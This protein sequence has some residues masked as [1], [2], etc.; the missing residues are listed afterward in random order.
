[1]G[2]LV[3]ASVLIA[4]IVAS[5]ATTSLAS[6]YYVAKWGD[7]GDGGSFDF[8]W[9]TIGKA[10]SVLV[11]GDTV[12]I[13]E[14]IYKESVNPS[15]SGTAG[16]PIV[17]E[18][19]QN[20]EIIVEGYE[21]IT[22]WVQDSVNRYMANVDFIPG[23]R[24]TTARD[25]RGNYG[26]LVLQDG[27]K[28]RYAMSPSQVD[29]DSAGEYYMD[30]SGSPPFTMYVYV[31]DLGS[32]YDPNNYVMQVGRYRKLFDLDGG[33]D[34]IHVIG[35]TLRGANDNA[36][37]SIGSN[38]CVFRRMTT[39][40]NFIT[41]I[42]LT[43][44]SR[45]GVIEQ[46]EF[47]D[48][49]HGGIELARAHSTTIRRNKFT[50][51]DL[52]NGFGG[53]GAHMWLG[54]LT[55]Y[56]DSCLI[57]NNIGFRTGS[58][59]TDIAFVAIR[60]EYNTVRHNSFLD[61]G[62]GGIA[63]IYGGNNTVINNAVNCTRGVACINVFPDAVAAGGHFI[64]YNDFYAEDP[65]GKYRWDGV[66]YDSLADW[67]AASGQSNNID[68]IPLWVDPA[69]EDLY[70]Q[71]GSDC[72]DAGTD[73]NASSEDY[74]GTPRPQGSGYDIGA[75]EYVETGVA[76]SREQVLSRSSLSL[77]FYPNPCA[78]EV[79]INY[80]I[81]AESL[82]VLQIYDITGRLVKSFAPG[83]QSPGTH[84]VN[85]RGDDDFGT[86]CPSGIYFCQLKT[87]RSTITEKLVLV[88]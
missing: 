38:Y 50:R 66:A 36:V 20:E 29:V 1:M 37:H 49:G 4:I 57:E 17:Y 81:Y 22:G 7:N 63:L 76:E 35:L 82:V 85:W 12:F 68:S 86:N 87:G 16:D 5:L 39:Y 19:Y 83:K 69:S 41:G 55:Q 75:Y 52:G 77:R 2:D 46:C 6:T 74:E 21:E 71:P 67:E 45:F 27:A 8:P 10:A 65:A 79:T 3:R 58:D 30:D 47:W 18:S 54:P 32:G 44:F 51:V 64:Q 15:N 33:E 31:R 26:G 62:L 73:V 72:I 60:G 43:S 84:S 11:A 88:D 42:Y 78:N 59:Y 34:Y 53:N 14:G 23:P 40:S 56:T 9:L 48:N 24:F 80:H 70:L 13:R 28:M 25:P 61:W